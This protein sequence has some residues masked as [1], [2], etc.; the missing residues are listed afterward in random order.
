MYAG[1]PMYVLAGHEG[2]PQG[3]AAAQI[4]V[5]ARF[6]GPIPHVH[7]EFDEAL[8]VLEGRLTVW[9]DGEPAEAAPGA[10]FTAPRGHRHGFAN[11]YDSP[12]LVL[13][14]WAPSKPAL[15]LMQEIG[16]AL[17][18]GS[19]PDPEEM[20]AIYSRHASRLLP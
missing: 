19:P 9:G 12:A 6:R 4:A 13:G 2:Q 7:D 3:F 15:A 17:A 1:E 18:P 10:M 20:R 16:A 8:Y 14:I 11:P 5:P